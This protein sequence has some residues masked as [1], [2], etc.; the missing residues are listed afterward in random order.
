MAL[1]LRRGL[2][3]ERYNPS[4]QTG[5]I[6]EEGELVYVTDTKQLWVGDG[7]TPGGVKVD[8]VAGSSITSIGDIP[9][10]DVTTSPP[11]MGE[12]LVWDGSQWVPGTV[13]S[14]GSGIVEGSNYRIG[15]VG[16]DSTVIINPANSSVNLDGTV[17]GNITPDANAVH[18]LGSD[19]ARFRDLYLSGSTIDL[20]GTKLGAFGGDILLGGTVRSNV[21]FGAGVD[22]FVDISS[23]E[24]QGLPPSYTFNDL[25]GPYTFGVKF[26]DTAAGGGDPEIIPATYTPTL[27]GSFYLTSVALDN[28]GFYPGIPTD[29]LDTDVTFLF[30]P[31]DPDQE[32]VVINSIDDSIVGGNATVPFPAGTYAATYS[33]TNGETLVVNYTV[34]TIDGLKTATINSF[35]QSDRFPAGLIKIGEST[36]YDPINGPYIFFY[37]DA[38]DPTAILYGD[39]RGSSLARETV[40]LGVNSNITFYSAD[41]NLRFTRVHTGG[42]DVDAA[43]AKVV[44]FSSADVDLI[45]QQNNLINL[46]S[47]LRKFA[48]VNTV[49]LNSNNISIANNTIESNVLSVLNSSTGA[50]MVEFGSASNLNSVFINSGPNAALIARGTI[51]P[52]VQPIL[53]V[54]T[55]RGTIDTPDSLQVGDEVGGILFQGYNTD[56]Y[57]V[58]GGL[59]TEVSSITP[60]SGTIGINLKLGVSTGSG[61][62]EAKVRSDGVLESAGAIKTGPYLNIAARDAALPIP[63][64]GMIV[65]VEDSDGF[66]T[67]KFQGYTGSAWVD[68]H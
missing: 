51:G 61:F 23:A 66:G 62:S 58:A 27:D 39:Y 26:T 44:D 4:T 34:S 38:N 19:T 37:I 20:D 22:G 55:S 67:P 28:P 29:V 9:D 1:R 16:D 57:Y 47:D 43:V 65:L 17:K 50:N 7:L 40:V 31:E 49:T 35:S 30:G 15:I 60:G 11:N 45:P 10:V 24:P 21:R 25:Y 56:D 12:V 53:I 48:S 18:D 14:D 54:Q 64:A 68:L 63:E 36:G 32:P 46:G 8:T 42:T 5:I 59:R 3:Q 52:G 2:E 6:F 13:A 41:L 33:A